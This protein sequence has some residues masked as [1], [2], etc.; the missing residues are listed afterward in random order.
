MWSDIVIGLV[1]GSLQGIFF[2]SFFD[3]VLDYSY[4][5]TLRIIKNRNFSIFIA[6]TIVLI[7]A[8][9]Y[10]I[11]VLSFKSL[12]TVWDVFLLTWILGFCLGVLATIVLTGK[13]KK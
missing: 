12:I 7:P 2:R 8:G 11:S 13:N 10:F 3:F 5:M 9:L 6:N 4:L 1:L